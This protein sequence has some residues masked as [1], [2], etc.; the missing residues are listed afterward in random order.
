MNANKAYTDEYLQHVAALDGDV[1]GMK[2]ARNHMS[3]PPRYIT[4]PW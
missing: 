4:A 3:I 1:Q 2:A